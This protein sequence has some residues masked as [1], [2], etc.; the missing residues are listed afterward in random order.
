MFLSIPNISSENVFVF[1]GSESTTSN[2]WLPF[3]IPSGISFVKFFVL[4]GGGNGSR[5]NLAATGSSTRGGGAGGGAGG[6]SVA[7]YP[8]R[9]LPSTIFLLPGASASPTYVSCTQSTATTSVLIYA[10][11]GGSGGAPAAAGSTAGAAAAV[12]VTSNCVLISQALDYSFLSGVAGGAGNDGTGAST[13]IMGTRIVVGGA[14]GGGEPQSSSTQSPGGDCTS[15]GT[16]TGVMIDG[17]GGSSAAA[18]DGTDGQW[19]WRPYML[20]QGGSGGRCM[21]SGNQGS[22]GQGVGYGCGGGGSGAGPSGGVLGQPGGPGYG[23]PGLI[24]ISCW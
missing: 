20:G 13:T 7:T 12:A 6:T 24:I 11:G 16:L 3:S 15:G 19:I 9:V 1:A 17:N 22:G 4:G 21:P 14:G 10:N 8:A 18:P 2:T 5:G 23:G